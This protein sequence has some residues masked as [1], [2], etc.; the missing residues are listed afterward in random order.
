MFIGLCIENDVDLMILPAHMSHKTQPLDVGVFAP[1]KRAMT[2]ETNHIATYSKGTIHKAIYTSLPIAA[3]SQA[4]TADNIK[5]RWRATGLWLLRPSVLLG[6]IKPPATPTPTA[7]QS[8]R[9]LLGLL[10]MENRDFIHDHAN[11][12]RTPAKHHFTSLSNRLEAALAKIA[13]LEREMAARM[14]WTE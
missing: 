13:L 4:M 9:T 8:A 5:S 12:L 2:R 3:R 1:L 6:D 10:M 14:S 11:S 7:S